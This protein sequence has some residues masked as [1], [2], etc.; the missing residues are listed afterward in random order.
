MTQN[1]RLCRSIF[2]QL[3]ALQ[4]L[5][6]LLFILLLGMGQYSQAQT[7]HNVSEAELE[8]LKKAVV[9]IYT[10]QAAPDY[11]I[12]WSLLNPG[13]GSGSGTV[14]AGQRIL[15]NAHVV[16]DARY[17]QVQKHD[18]PKKY[19][20]RVAFVSHEADLALI[21][22]DDAS[23]FKGLVPL[24]F[25]KLPEPLQEV[26][27][28]GY[29]FG[30]KSLSITRGILSR[31]EHQFYA[32][33]G[34]YLLA[35]Q[36]DAAINPGNSGGPVI[37]DQKIVGV[38]MQ[39]NSSSRA[40]NLGYFVPPSVIQHVLKD[41]EDGKYDG[42]PDL[43]FR[44]Q[45]LESPAM[46]KAYGLSNDKSGL[47]VTK[48]FAESAA[49]G[50]IKEGDLI[51]SIDG[52]PIADDRSVEFRRYQRTNYKFV[53]DQFYQGDKIPMQLLR[54][55]KQLNVTVTAKPLEFSPV[56]VLPEAFDELPQYYIYGGV[57][58]V[59][60]NMNLIK[61]WGQNW[62][63]KAPV[64][65]LNARDTWSSPEQQEQV[66]AL[67]VLA[68]DVNLGYHDWK[69]WLVSRVNGQP[70]VN[71]RQFCELLENNQQTFVSLEDNQGYRM[72]ID[73]AMAK[74]TQNDILQRYQIP[75]AYSSTLFNE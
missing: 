34:S 53:I 21:E 48:V 46:K 38:V 61:R 69:N 62:N 40:E 41:A 27:V 15:T 57:V 29:P 10:T 52:Y 2:F 14:I 1:L 73:H 11:F 20:A 9:K 6:R 4:L 64:Q 70:I 35:G 45:G 44:T 39:S 16:A 3:T 12:P 51:L 63:N 60:L 17:I 36:L 22:V 47:V 32:H 59:P 75:S 8:T 67:K 26:S 43:G 68:A 42:F 28:F 65:F 33:A 24:G 58:F 49:E 55:G 25:G 30:G 50:V 19:L 18:D 31:V 23:F 5:P 37:Q 71:F 66:V 72:V 7:P 13:Q 54:A 56:V 74:A